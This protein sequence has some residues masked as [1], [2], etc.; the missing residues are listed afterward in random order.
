LPVGKYKLLISKDK[1]SENSTFEIT[2]PK[3]K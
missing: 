2:A 3:K 1:T